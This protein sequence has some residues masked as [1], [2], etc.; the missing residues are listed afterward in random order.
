MVTKK[1]LADGVIKFISN[2][3]MGDIDDR[4]LKFTLCMAK[5]AL[6]ENPDILDAFLDSPIIANVIHEQD[7]EY[8]VDTFARTLKNVLSEYDSYPI[9]IPAIPMFSKDSVIR[10]TA[11]DVDKILGYLSKEPQTTV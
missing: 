8:N 1:E 11:E 4:H 7:G 2:D 5:K 10:I 6:H 9:H 3:L